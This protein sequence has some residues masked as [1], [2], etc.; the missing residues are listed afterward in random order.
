M[1]SERLKELRKRDGLSQV[2]FAKQFNIS[3][4]TIGNW[5]TGAREPDATT[6][7]KIAKFFN[8]TV[9]YLLNDDEKN[10]P[11]QSDEAF[12]PELTEKDELDI[13]KR[14][15][16]VLEDLGST[17]EAL[18]FDG[19]PLELD[20]ETRDALIKSIENSIRMGKLIAKQKYTP[21]KYWKDSNNEG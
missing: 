7:M 13:S 4:G 5:E 6:L 10:A 16:A 20:D 3:T 1:L 2:E 19:E 12:E 15:N 9:D 11:P 14:L 21:K 18:M 17:G 8:V